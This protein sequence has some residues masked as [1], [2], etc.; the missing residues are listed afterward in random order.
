MDRVLENIKSM[1]MRELD[2]VSSSGQLT[3]DSLMCVDKMVDIIKDLGEIEEKEMGGYSNAGRIPMY[4]YDMNSYGGRMSYNGSNSYANRNYNSY[5][6]GYS[7]DNEVM[8]KLNQMMNETSSP[9]ERDAIRRVMD[10]IKM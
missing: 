3:N 8:D 9:Q 6:N 7:R 10:K 2:N 1:V 4:P 5:D